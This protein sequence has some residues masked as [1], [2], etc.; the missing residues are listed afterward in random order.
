MRA[1]LPTLA[2]A[3]RIVAVALVGLSARWQATTPQDRL[4]PSEA[5]QNRV[6]EHAVQKRVPPRPLSEG[7]IRRYQ[8]QLDAILAVVD[9]TPLY[10]FCSCRLADV[11]GRSSHEGR[12]GR[13]SG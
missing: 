4:G 9:V 10:V 3:V 7:Q 13:N 2:I 1:L 11:A 5:Q 12:A 6:Q 8:A